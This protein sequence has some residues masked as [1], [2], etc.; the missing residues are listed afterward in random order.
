MGHVNGGKTFF[1]RM[2]RK[3]QQSS[4]ASQIPEFISTHPHS[5]NRIKDLE[6]YGTKKGYSWDGNLLPN[7]FEVSK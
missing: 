6:R 1:K 2:S 7:T 4:F 5:Q 3:Q